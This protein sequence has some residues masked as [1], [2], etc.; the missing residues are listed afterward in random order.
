MISLLLRRENETKRRAHKPEFKAKVALAA[1]HELE[2]T[3][4]TVQVL[5][6]ITKFDITSTLPLT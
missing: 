2:S 5:G 4:S 6:S 1:V 3:Y